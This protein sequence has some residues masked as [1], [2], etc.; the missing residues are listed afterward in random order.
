MEAA[1]HEIGG[2]VHAAGPFY[3]VGADQGYVVGAQHFDE[4]RDQETIVADFDGVAHSPDGVDFH[5]GAAGDALVVAARERRRG[6]CVAGE[7]FQE[8]LEDRGIEP[9]VWGKLP[10]DGTEFGAQAQEA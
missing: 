8:R 10:E 3:R 1:I 2:E 7:D 4:F 9:E 5:G 6:L